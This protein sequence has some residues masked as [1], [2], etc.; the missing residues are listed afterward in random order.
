MDNALK[1]TVG[2]RFSCA[3]I[4]DHSVRCWGAAPYRGSAAQIDI[5]TPP[6]PVYRIND[7]TELSSG[8]PGSCV[9]DSNRQISCWGTSSQ[10][11]FPAQAERRFVDRFWQQVEIGF[12]HGCGVNSDASLECWGDNT[13][14]SLGDGT[15]THSHEALIRVGGL[16]RVKRLQSMNSETTC[17]IDVEDRA[18]C[19]GKNIN[20]RIESGGPDPITEPVRISS[21]PTLRQIDIGTSCSCAVDTAGQVI[22]WGASSCQAPSR[23]QDPQNLER[24]S[25]E[26]LPGQA[27]EVQTGNRFACALDQSGQV[28]CWGSNTWGQLGDGT[29]SDRFGVVVRVQGLPPARQIAAR[30]HVCAL[31]HDRSVYC[32][33][34]NRDNQLGDGRAKSTTTPMRAPLF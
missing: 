16:P 18:W 5:N 11:G 9:L 23:N 8:G 15:T 34:F 26:G 13:W 33:G 25:I 10:R 30:N 4:A 17:V 6:S 22:C 28:H 32:W 24:R 29:A 19:W 21:L 7:A 1:V 27:I 2:N 20:G 31:T 3:L 12:A 14:G